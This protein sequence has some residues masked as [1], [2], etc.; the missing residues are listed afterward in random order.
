MATS[1]D[2]ITVYTAFSLFCEG[3]ATNAPQNPQGAVQTDGFGN[4]ITPARAV[5]YRADVIMHHGM[6][7][8]V[9]LVNDW[10]DYGAGFIA[11]LARRITAVAA[12][13]S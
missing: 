3:D 9:F 13:L 4:A 8:E 5:E 11:A 1:A 2:L 10:T 6:P 7:Y 12:Q